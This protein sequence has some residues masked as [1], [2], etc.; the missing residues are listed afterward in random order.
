MER[1]GF[2]VKAADDPIDPWTLSVTGAPLEPGSTP[3]GEAKVLGTKEIPALLAGEEVHF[4]LDLD[5]RGDGDL[6][7]TFRVEGNDELWLFPSS[8]ILSR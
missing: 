7:L 4:Y 1:F 2:H 5:L 3:A 6:S 8:R